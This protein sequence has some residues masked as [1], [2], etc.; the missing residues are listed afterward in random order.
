MVIIESIR[1]ALRSLTANKLR[2]ALTMLGIIIGVGAVIALM[3]IGQGVQT[4]IVS[5]LQANGTNLLYIQPG[6]TSQGGVSQGAGSAATLT[7]ADANALSDPDVAPAVMA[8]APES[9]AS[10]QLTYQGQNVRSRVTG[11]TP[12][13]A[14]VRN[15]SISEGE[16]LTEAHL[17][18]NASVAVLGPTVAANLFGDGDPVGQSIKINGVPFRVIGVTAAKGGTGFGSQ[19][20]VVFVPLTTLSARLARSGT[21][22]GQI[23]VSTISVQ[24]ADASQIQTVITQISEVLRERHQLTSGDDDF[25]VTSLDDILKTATQ[26]TDTLTI[27]LGGIAAISL[28]VGGIGIMNIMLV[29]VTERTREI[30]IRKALGA[31]R[32]DILVQFLAE[33]MVLSI[34]GGGIGTLL[35]WG[36]SQL[37]K[38]VSLGST[39]LSPVVSADAVLLATLFS[40][41]I[42]LFFGIYPANRAASLN[43]IE[44]LRFE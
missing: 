27:F 4:S 38:G 16:W 31:K 36:V 7:L 10:A 44:A 35:G 15:V 14:V 12:A 9:G 1:I 41:A 6:S 18:A 23:L 30:G 24:V 19:D 39:T 28:V 34:A 8:V 32:R 42:G 20:D 26:V 43:P 29:S 3:A 25:R 40:T 22:R 5:S 37:I 21:Y 33:A 11:V 2:S 17:T 13:Y